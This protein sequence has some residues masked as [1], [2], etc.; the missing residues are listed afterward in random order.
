MALVIVPHLIASPSTQPRSTPKLADHSHSLGPTKKT[1]PL[2]SDSASQKVGKTH[3]HH[4]STST[5]NNGVDE[6][7]NAKARL[8]HKWT[9]SGHEAVAEKGSKGANVH[10]STSVREQGRAK[11]KT[12]IDGLRKG[13]LLKPG[14]TEWERRSDNRF[15]D[16]ID[17]KRVPGQE[18]TI[19]DGLKSVW[20]TER[21]RAQ[22]R[23]QEVLPNATLGLTLR[24]PSG[25][26]RTHP[27]VPARADH[28]VPV[29][30][31]SGFGGR[32]GAAHRGT[33]LRKRRRV[34]RLRR[35]SRPSTR[36]ERASSN[37]LCRCTPSSSL[38]RLC[39]WLR[40]GSTDSSVLVRPLLTALPP[41]ARTGMEEHGGSVTCSRGRTP[42]PV[43]TSLLRDTEPGVLAANG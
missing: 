15:F 34:S 23:A 37:S 4:I 6:N 14:T 13:A 1:R 33:R 16:H 18:Q 32:H 25:D 35:H 8:L 26:C 39:D 30:R 36:I 11:T 20:Q 24:N 5:D 9:H 43:A 12:L 7:A 3:P 28:A 2:R 38:L 19:R 40:L 31:R 21:A 17:T 22:E 29:R 42:A 41:F 10:S 27:S